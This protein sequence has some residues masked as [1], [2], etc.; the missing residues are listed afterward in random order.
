MFF[1]VG[2]VMLRRLTKSCFACYAGTQSK[3][4]SNDDIGHVLVFE[5]RVEHISNCTGPDKRI[6]N[7]GKPS[8]PSANCPQQIAYSLNHS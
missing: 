2:N 3:H 1:P 5:A 6:F 4:I 8:N 7:I